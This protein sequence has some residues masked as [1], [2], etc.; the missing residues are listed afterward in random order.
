[1]VTFY[2]RLPKFEYVEL[3][4]IGKALDLF[5]DLTIARAHGSYARL[6]KRLLKAKVLVM[7]DLGLPPM[8]ASERRDLLEVVED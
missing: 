5:E 7:D 4:S 6:I 1:M 2:G 8:S 3:R